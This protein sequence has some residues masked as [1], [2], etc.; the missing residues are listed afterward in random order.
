[1]GWINP[2]GA[3]RLVGKT[4]KKEPNK[5]QN[6]CT[7]MLLNRTNSLIFEPWI[8]QSKVT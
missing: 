2:S 5:L 4:R 7:K 1:M 6:S 3:L 8:A